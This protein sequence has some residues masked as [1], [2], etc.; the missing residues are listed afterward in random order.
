[1]NFRGVF[2]TSEQPDVTARFYRDVA[3]VA[4]E[5]VDSAG[6]YRYWKYDDGQIQIAIHDARAFA[7]YAFPPRTDSNVTHMYFHI[8]D[9]AAFLEQLRM[10][11]IEPKAV[12]PVVITLVDP[13]GRIVLFGTA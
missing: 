6:T 1:M 2:L 4:I 7:D 3:R 5:E 8:A 13:D 9:H 10:Q 11:H 12:D